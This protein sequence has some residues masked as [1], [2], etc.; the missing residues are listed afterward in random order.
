M[1]TDIRKRCVIT[2]LSV[3]L[4]VAAVLAPAGCDR[5]G[6]GGASNGTSGG[7]E[8]LFDYRQI[9]LDNGLRVV[10]LED[11]SCPIVSVQ[12]WYHVGSKDEQPNRQGYA[13]MFEHM[14][15]KGTDRVGPKD[16]FGLINK[17]GGTL[18]AY[19]S[20]DRTVYHE[21]LPVEQ[22]EL[23]LWLES[24]RMN[25]LKIDQEAFDTER[26]VVLEELRMGENR[27]YGTL[28]KKIMG[29]LF[30]EH[31]Y[32][33]RPIGNM[34]DLRATSV[35]NLRSFWTKYYVP[36]N[37]VLVI[38]GAVSHEKAQAQAKRY[39]GWVPRCA[40][41]PRVSIRE[42]QW[43]GARTI[44]ID[45]EN[46]PAAQSSLIWRT[47]PLGHKDEPALDL[48]AEI[49]GGGN[50]S[51]LYRE[52]VA[53]KQLAVEAS[54]S[55]WNLEHDGLFFADVTLADDADAEQILKII[56]SHVRKIKN[57]GVSEGELTKARNQMLKSTVMRNLTIN[58]KAR[59]LASAAVEK[60]DVS[61]ANMVF[62]EIRAVTRQ[63]IQAV[64]RKYLRDDR[65]ITLIVEKNTSG[66]QAGAK[67]D[68]EAPITAEPEL[69]SPPPGR[70]GVKRPADFPSAPPI[71][72][73]VKDIPAP[74]FTEK[75]LPNGLKVIVVP[76]HE[77]PFISVT[78]G[79]L[80]GAWTE[81][82]PG[83]AS[84][85]LQMLT[86]GTAR[87][88]ESALAEEL[89]RYAIA[90]SGSAEMDT[91]SVDAS[92]LTDQIERTMKL[93]AE[94]VL[95]PTFDAGEFDK[96]RKQVLTSLAIQ[97]KTPRYMVEK[98]FRR[99]LYGDHPYSRTVQ[100]EIEDV[101]ALTVDDL[102]RWWTRFAQPAQARLI[103]TGDIDHDRAVELAGRYLGN[104]KADS[105]AT[106]VSL[107]TITQTKGRHIYIVDTPGSAQCEIR[108]GH[109]S[110]TRHDQPEYFI[111][112]IVGY[113]FGGS[114]NSRLNEIIR[115]KKGL[116]Y[117]AGG[118]WWAQRFAGRFVVSTFT[119]TESLVETVQTIFEEI[120]R[121]A[122]DGPSD[123]ELNDTKNYIAGSFV[124][125]RETPQ[126]VAED[127]WLIE[128]NGLA[129]DYI[130]KLLASI[131]A[132]NKDECTGLVAETIDSNRMIVVVTG[133]A[134]KIKD[135]LEK[136]APVTVVRDGE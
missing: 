24:E 41:V 50:S 73:L 33:W 60:G 38:V 89:E 88:D 47:V 103:F 121:M 19:T 30:K 59:I 46:A 62:E 64:A 93:M 96:L 37:A 17:T 135:E 25:F 130:E 71:G 23:A 84:A 27:P 58:S 44:V 6:A 56:K 119:K 107:P 14:M 83:T 120:D 113:Y 20:F 36:N 91:S 109:T 98:E 132:T 55:T 7:S 22:L 104:W 81:S 43:A 10:T 65:V 77:V 115:I 1:D 114:F 134:E 125:W 86:K 129:K 133:D 15:F 54:A 45:D 72:A 68:E 61:R 97:A 66:M 105:P 78:L 32:R 28:F 122:K 53:D 108:I 13:H 102:K 99:R 2:V 85:A 67:D 70:D 26:N 18:N 21:T 3:L 128:S 106:K 34:A 29:E 126:Q 87:H 49:L 31:P 82:R 131:A 12:V 94:V 95:E 51:R 111:S 8:K 4:A 42:P 74:K 35:A 124:R 136:I 39:F 5:P 11:F 79:F 80:N 40:D 75:K 100:G 16:H 112:R 123:D 101:K 48:L 118:G 57:E 116:T 69:Q 117:G 92:C 76:N 63:D 110:I 52:L 9:T 127:L 90:L